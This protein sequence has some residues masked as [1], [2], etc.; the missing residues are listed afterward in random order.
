M[1]QKSVIFVTIW[2]SSDLNEAAGRC[3]LRSAGVLIFPPGW[4][5]S[6]RPE[7]RARVPPPWVR[8]RRCG[9]A[10]STFAPWRSFWRW[11]P[12]RTARARGGV[13]R[14]VPLRED[15]SLALGRGLS[16]RRP[17][18]S[19]RRAGRV[20]A[21]EI[22]DD[23]LFPSEF[24]FGVAASSFQI[25]GDGGDRPRSVWDDFADRRDLGE[26]ARAGIRHYEHRASDIRF[27]ARAG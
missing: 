17:R 12:R 14:R 5:S 11:S 22:G 19:H 26:D 23:D 15:R 8:D 25:E 4:Q 13:G 7:R 27:M 9:R 21:L 16:S 20:P 18:A 24:V 3:L 1:T 10:R 2:L 6:R